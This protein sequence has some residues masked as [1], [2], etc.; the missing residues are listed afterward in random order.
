MVG[1]FYIEKGEWILENLT[2]KD[3]IQGALKA[4]T[5]ETA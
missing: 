2:D 5:K 3:H 1:G 4:I